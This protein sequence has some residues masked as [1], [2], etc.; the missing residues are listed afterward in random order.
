MSFSYMPNFDIPEDPNRQIPAGGDYPTKEM[1]S[2]PLPSPEKVMSSFQEPAGFTT[3]YNPYPI[4]YP[5]GYPMN[6]PVQEKAKV[7]PPTPSFGMMGSCIDIANHVQSC[8]VCSRLYKC[9]NSI[10][11]VIIMIL[12]ILLIFMGKK[13]LE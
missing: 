13:Y 4:N 6:Y 10:H 5:M 12:L 1:L 7:E 8:P 9:D 3:P 11:F 2:G